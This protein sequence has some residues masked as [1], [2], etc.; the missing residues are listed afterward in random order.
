MKNGVLNVSEQASA[1]IDANGIKLNLT[2]QGE[3]LIFGNTVLD[4]NQEVKALVQAIKDIDASVVITLDNIK[5]HS[6]TG[7]FTQISKGSYNLV[8]TIANLEK[9]DAILNTI[10]EID[11]VNLNS[12]EWLYDDYAAKVKLITEAVTKAKAKAETM[13]AAL[14]KTIIGIKSCGDSYDMSDNKAIT[15]EEAKSLG[16]S[17]LTKSRSKANA[18]MGTLIKGKKEIKATAFIQFLLKNVEE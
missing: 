14:G 13:A 11:H 1:F 12:I 5:I 18:D 7:W 3:N 2:I 17:M 16:Y 4:K 10:I 8:V 15:Q 6:E 9:I